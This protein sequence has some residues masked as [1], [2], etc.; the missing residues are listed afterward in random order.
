MMRFRF[1]AR[2]AMLWAVAAV[3]LATL[4]ACSSPPG[5]FY[6]LGTGDESA[7]EIGT[8]HPSYLIDM[9]QVKVPASV[10]RSQLVVQV[11]TAQVK[12]L[13]DDRWAS[14]VADEIHNAL[15]VAVA[16]QAGALDAK[17]FTRSDNVPVYQISADVQR[18]ESWPASHALIDVVWSIRASNASQ[19]LVCRSLV[20]QHVSAGYEALVEGHRRAIQTLAA[21]I[22]AGLRD[23]SARST[24]VH[25][26]TGQ[27]ALSCPSL[28]RPSDAGIEAP[29]LGA[30]H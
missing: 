16:R 21:Q 2:C 14:P 25:G 24:T 27:A 17:E 22:A 28:A 30:A 4:G 6:T 3:G 29:V 11:N 5:R 8:T 26:G 7:I 12:I 9:R 15:L 20:S 19:T 10:A 18:F 23:L 1:S 13:E